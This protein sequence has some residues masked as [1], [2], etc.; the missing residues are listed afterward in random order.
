MLSPKIAEQLRQRGYDAYAIPERPDLVCLSDE[1]VLGLGAEERRVVV[2]LNI[3][4]FAA[5]CADWRAGSRSHSGIV[6]VSAASFPQDR[7]FPGALVNAPDE[8]GRA[9][10]LPGPDETCFLSR[11]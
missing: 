3:A 6:Y 4:D 2:T 10:R 9:D 8:A 1:Q 7:A 11:A 5:L